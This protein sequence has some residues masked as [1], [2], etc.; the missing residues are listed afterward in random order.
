[1]FSGAATSDEL[2]K[3]LSVGADDFLIKPLS[4][5]TL[6]GRVLSALRMKDAQ[7]RGDLLNCRLQAVNEELERNLNAKEGDLVQARNALVLALANLVDHRDAERA[8][9]LAP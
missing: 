6:Q 2:A 8:G 1:M 5:V 3:M 4:I 9:R 7:D